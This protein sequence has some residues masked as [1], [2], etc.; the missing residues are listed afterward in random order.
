MEMT[1]PDR[2]ALAASCRDA[3][4]I[5]KV[6]DAGIVFYN[7]SG[8]AI[9]LMHNGVQ[10]VANGYYGSVVSDIIKRLRGHHEPQE[11]KVFH[12]VLKLVEPGS[13]MI[14]LG[15]YWSYYSLWFHQSVSGAINYMVE[16]VLD[17][18]E[19]GKRNFRLN[20]FQ[21]HFIHA[22]VGDTESIQTQPPTITVDGLAKREGLTKIEILHADIQGHEYAM[23][24]GARDLLGSKLVRFAFIST[25]GFKVHGKC[26][27]LLGKY[28]YKVIAE[29]TP[30]ESYSVD[31]L[32]VASADS[33]IGKV[34]ITRKPQR[35]DERAKSLVCRC[36]SWFVG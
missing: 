19:I 2:V 34:E 26:L 12:E 23:L 27:G 5:P 6:Q 13:V 16:P 30:G 3:D 29:H 21:G 15:A 25:H 9:Q 8:E 17:N 10:V 36:L 22:L 14:E 1:Q 18:L 33:N 32:I 28:H 11:E 20:D 31:G 24:L 35:V 4:A 7:A